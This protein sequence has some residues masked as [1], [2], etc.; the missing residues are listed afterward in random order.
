MLNFSSYYSFFTSSSFLLMSKEA[1]K[2]SV[3]GNT[4]KVAIDISPSM[5]MIEE[6]GTSI[7]NRGK[8]TKSYRPFIIPQ[9]YDMAPDSITLTPTETAAIVLVAVTALYA[10]YSFASKGLS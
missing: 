8:L 7:S 4:S 1:E 5:T 6:F 3:E 9:T 2:R 10:N